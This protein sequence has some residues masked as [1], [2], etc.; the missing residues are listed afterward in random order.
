[1]SGHLSNIMFIGAIQQGD[2][3]LPLWERLLYLVPF[4][5]VLVQRFLFLDASGDPSDSTHSQTWIALI[6]GTVEYLIY[7]AIL[8]MLRRCY[9]PSNGP[10]DL[11][12]SS[13]TRPLQKP[14]KNKNTTKTKTQRKQKHNENKNTT[15]T[16]TQRKQKHNENKNTTKT[17]TQRKQKHKEIFFLSR[18]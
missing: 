3:R 17:K 9:P 4:P 6:A 1:M 5:V 15:K 8:A 2:M 18:S 10:S 16:K 7:I 13:R 14:E 12:L 11:P